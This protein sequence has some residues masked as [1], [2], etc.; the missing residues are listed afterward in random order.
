MRQRERQLSFVRPGRTL[1]MVVGTV[2]L[3]GA[4]GGSAT[5]SLR[6]WEKS[7]AA[8]PQATKPQ[9]TKP[10]PYYTAIDGL[11]L[12]KEPRRSKAHL[13]QRPLHQKVYRSKLEGGYAYVKVDGSDMKGWVDNA[14]LIW[15]LPAEPPDAPAVVE[16]DAGEPVVEEAVAPPEPE[17]SPDAP[18]S[19]SDTEPDSPD[20]PSS[21][22]DTEP[23]P[24]ASPSVFDRF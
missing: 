7:E 12:Y 14:Q 13:A 5:K 22:S 17:R 9:A 8:K 16:E 23:E 20:A 6:V 4:C 15:R 1:V 19:V 24:P 2:A 21:V 10:Q 18:S 3:L 11:K